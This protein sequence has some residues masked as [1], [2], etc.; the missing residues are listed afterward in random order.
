MIITLGK[1]H[2]QMLTWFVLSQYI[3]VYKGN[4]LDYSH[5]VIMC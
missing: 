2:I 5:K 1:L 3:F 4:M